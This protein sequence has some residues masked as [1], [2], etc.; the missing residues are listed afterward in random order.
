MA[1]RRT[2]RPEKR[3]DRQQQ[4]HQELVASAGT[5]STTDRVTSFLYELMRDHVPPG[6]V[7]EMLCNTPP[8]RQKLSNGWLARYA[9]W[10]SQELQR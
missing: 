9:Y 7:Q 8:G 6:V 4:L 5:F 10:V 2:K 1:R 3:S